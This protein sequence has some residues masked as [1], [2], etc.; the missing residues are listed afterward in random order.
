MLHLLS[1]RVALPLLLSFALLLLAACGGGDTAGEGGGGG[2]ANTDPIKVGAIFDLTGATSDVGALY[3]E[4][5]KGYVD[6]V[7]QNGGIG[8][9]QLDLVSA[10]YAYAVDQ[11]EQL[12]SQYVNQD[13]V[14]VFS[15]WGTGD[16]EALR[17]RIAD[18]QIPFV[19]ASYSAALADPAEAP[20]NFL[21]GTTYSDQFILAIDKA[22]E[23]A[24]DATTIALFH[25][26]SPFGTSPLEDG[27]A[28]AESKGVEVLAFPM[29]RGA[30]DFTAELTQAESAGVTHIVVQN[31][32]SPA[33]TLAK[34]VSD[35]GL[36]MRIMC[37]NWCT[38]EV[39]TELGGESVNGVIGVNPFT[40]PSSG[41]AGL[42]EIRTYLEGEGKS[43]EEEGGLYVA[44]WLTM[45]VLLKGVE[46]TVAAGQPVTGA[47]I[48]AA[49]EQ[50]SNYDTG[51]I[52]TPLTF[53]SENHAGNTSVQFFEVQDGVWVPL[54]DRVSTE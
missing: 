49:L 28:H 53:T 10:D 1:K 33:A 19:S 47:N 40:F 42:D 25:N 17:T 27:R 50:L 31:V 32:S 15:G 51:G 34:N 35:Q 20:Y 2:E 39:L 8:G 6:F 45:K 43:L 5:I 41:V 18:D 52:T 13:E 46:D 22:I 30:T 3:A 24:G 14:V 29:P 23:E 9:R 21:V 54:G 36:D 44:G 48:K 4:G 38:N 26:D 16:T 12:Y 37:L 11:A 7:N